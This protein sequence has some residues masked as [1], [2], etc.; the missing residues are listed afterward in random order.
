MQAQDGTQA[1]AIGTAGETVRAKTGVGMTSP[2]NGKVSTDRMTGARQREKARAARKAAARAVYTVLTK[3][4]TATL[5]AVR[6]TTAQ[7]TTRR[8]HSLQHAG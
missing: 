6:R 7:L 8:R 4:M 2:K 3:P 1:R 5:D